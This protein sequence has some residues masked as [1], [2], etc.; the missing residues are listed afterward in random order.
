MTL[1]NPSLQTHQLVCG[2]CIVQAEDAVNTDG[3]QLSQ[4]RVVAEQLSL[5]GEGSELIVWST[6]KYGRLTSYSRVD[7]PANLIVIN[8]DAKRK[9]LLTNKFAARCWCLFVS[10]CCL[11]SQRV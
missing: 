7:D 10:V 1:R 2:Y 8:V 3:V 9:C 5:V 6:D 4:V 11:H